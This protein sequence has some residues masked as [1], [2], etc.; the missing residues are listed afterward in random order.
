MS[1]E[2]YHWPPEVTAHM[3]AAGWSPERRVDV[4][5]WEEELSRTSGFRMHTAAARF[6]AEFGGLKVPEGPN[7]PGQQVASDE[8]DLDPLEGEKMRPY[9]QRVGRA[10]VGELYP[11][12]SVAGGH[13]LLAIDEAE[14]VFMLFGDHCRRIGVGR[15]AIANLILGRRPQ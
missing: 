5:A 4:S 6:L 7:E 15:E 12:G 11:I 3:T 1:A 10:A 13:A 14:T 8:F 9:F 2:A